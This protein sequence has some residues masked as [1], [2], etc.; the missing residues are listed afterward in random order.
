MNTF[1]LFEKFCTFKKYSY[2]T[3][4]G[5]VFFGSDDFALPF[6]QNLTA[7]NRYVK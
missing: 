2:R 7:D 6:L 5:V 4:T 1:K 3:K